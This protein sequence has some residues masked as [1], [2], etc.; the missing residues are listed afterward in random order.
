MSDPITLTLVG[1]TAITEGIKFLYSQAEDLL[2]RWR[3]KKEKATAVVEAPQPQE[4]VNLP[5]VF[6]ASK[7]NPEVRDNILEKFGNDIA[8]LMEELKQAD[9]VNDPAVL[10]N[11]VFLE[12]LDGLRRIIEAVYN[13]KLIFKEELN[14]PQGP[15]VNAEIV[16]NEVEGTVTAIRAKKIGSG[17]INAKVSAQDVRPGGSL[18]G[19]DIDSIG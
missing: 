7:L 5:P 8:G 16:V 15:K 3:D 4:Q 11:E 12:K 10:K 13:Q 2:I 9:A 6:T 18:T 14:A 17:T 19:L 1:T